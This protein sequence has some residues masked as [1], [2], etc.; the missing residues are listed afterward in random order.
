MEEKSL[1]GPWLQTA[2]SDKSQ[3]VE[4]G[5]DSGGLYILNVSLGMLPCKY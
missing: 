4:G 2:L 1:T 5:G 3:L